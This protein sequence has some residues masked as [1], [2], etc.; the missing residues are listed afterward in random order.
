MTN[1]ENPRPPQVSRAALPEAEQPKRPEVLPQEF[2][3]ELAIS[4]KHEMKHE[5]QIGLFDGP[6]IEYMQKLQALV[7]DAANRLLIGIEEERRHKH[8]MESGFAAERTRGQIFAFVIALVF[9]GGSFYLIS[10]GHSGV[11]IAAVITAI[12]SAAGLFVYKT[13]IESNSNDSE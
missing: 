2:A 13:K 5:I 6:S 12:V 7:P 10:I 4:L 8:K 11:G 9:L 3:R 1:S